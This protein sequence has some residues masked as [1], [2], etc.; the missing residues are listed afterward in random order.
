MKALILAGGMG[1]RL[2]PFTFSIPKPLLPVGERAIIEVVIA[3][4]SASGI[5]DVIVSTGYLSDLIK[6][7]CRDGRQ[8]GVQITY[9][10]EAK[11]LGT[12][13]P[14]K[15]AAKYMGPGENFILMNGDLITDLNFRDLMDYHV[16][17]RFQITMAYAEIVTK[18]PFGV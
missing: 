4:L 1:T 5:T 9:V 18:S 7:Y 10:H 12:A 6:A 2:R 16:N 13:G 11:P 8:W 15:L 14:A 3:R 17:N